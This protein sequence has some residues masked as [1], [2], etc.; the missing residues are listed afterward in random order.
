MENLYQHQKRFLDLNVNKSLLCWDTGTGKTRAS[1][2][3]SKLKGLGSTIL[4]ICPK[5]LKE[6]WKRHS[7]SVF[8]AGAIPMI[9]TK[10]EFRRDWEKLFAYQTIIVDEAHYFA[11][12]KSQMSK[13]LSK[14]VKKWKVQNILLLTATPYRSSPWDIYTL[15]KHLGYEWNWFKFSDRFFTEIYVGRGRKVPKVKEGIE[16]EL[17]LLVSK[18]GNIVKIGDCA[19]IPEQVF[20]TEYYELTKEQ[21]AKK[22]ET[23]DANP[24]VRYTRHHEIENGVLVSDGYVPDIMNIP[25]NKVERIL[26]LCEENKKIIIVC[27]YNLQIDALHEQ[28]KQTGKKVYIIRGDVKNRDAVVREADSVSEAIVLVQAACSEG[29]ELPSIPLMVFASMD[30]SYVNYKQMCGRI[31]RLNKLK[32]NVYLHLVSKG[33][34]TAVYNAIM[35]KQDFSLAIYADKHN[36]STIEDEVS[37]EGLPD[38]F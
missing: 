15:A 16:D 34:D 21:E 35:K 29:Y 12:T 4:I 38:G 26:E 24:I 25:Y 22:K 18:I 28:C 11:G 36:D 33:I 30:F 5:A 17:A 14:Y 20:E 7:R 19:D 31:L 8:T 10:E 3:W 27:R 1:L 9:L 37:G 13:S 2:E 6:N 32:K 23:Y